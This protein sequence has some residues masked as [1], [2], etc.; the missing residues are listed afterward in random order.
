MAVIGDLIVRVGA[1]IEGFERAMG[2]VS[3]R[4]V[5][6]DRDA[7]KSIAGFDRIGDRLTDIGTT[8][9]I[10]ITAPLAAVAGASIKTAS[11]FESSMNRVSALGEITGKDLDDLRA[12]ALKLG[13]D[14][15]FSAKQA[16]DGMGELAAAGFSATQVMQAMPGVLNLAAAGQLEIAE[17]AEISA[18]VLQG[19]GLGADQAT[20]AADVLAKA[21]ASGSV[22]VQDLGN[23]FRYVG[24]VAQA[25][26]L[27]FEEVAA[28]TTLLSNAGIK[29]EAA[30]TGLRGMLA[31]LLD[32]AP[33]AAAALE[34]LGV[35]TQDA[36]E[37]LLP[38]TEIIGQLGAKGATTSD[39][40][41]IFG[42]ETA[43]A[44]QA[45]VTTGAPALQKMTGELQNAEGAAD[46]M[47]KTI[48]AGTKGAMEQF[49][50]S[51]E[52]LGISLGT[53][54]LP[55][56]N[57]IVAGATKLINEFLIPAAEWFAK[58]PSPIQNVALGLTAAAAAAG[59]LLL[60]SGQLIG[61]MTQ[62]AG[63]FEFV[64]KGMGTLTGGAGL[65]GSLG[66]M[67]SLLPVLT[68]LV[69]ALGAAIAA[70]AIYEGV[71]QIQALNKE[72]DRLYDAQSRGVKASEDQA[73][74]IGILEEVLRKHG[75]T[76]DSTGK[77][78][79]EYLGAL[80]SATKGLDD[81]KAETGAMSDAAKDLERR[82]GLTRGETKKLEDTQK[83][84]VRSAKE[85]EAQ[86]DKAATSLKR[87]N[88][89]ILI[90][91]YQQWQAEH[92]N[93]VTSVATLQRAIE[94]GVAGTIDFNAQLAELDEISRTVA[95]SLADVSK[96]EIP[97]YLQSIN[98]GVAATDQL[99]EAFKTLGVTTT[100]SLNDKAAKAQ[101]AYETIKSSGIASA[102]EVLQAERA[103]LQASIEAR[104]AAGETITQEE[105]ARLTSLNQSL[106][107]HVEEQKGLFDG[108]KNQVSTIMTDLSKG[109]SDIIFEG[110][111]FGET[112]KGIFEEMG[113]S[114]LR[115]VV[116]YLEGKLVKALTGLLD[117]PLKAVGGAIGG[118]FGI[119]SSAVSAATSAA[120]S[121]AGGAG[122][123]SGGV[124]SAVGGAASGVAGIVGAIGS[125]GS[126]AT[127]V[128]GLFQNSG[129]NENLQLIENNTRRLEI[130]FAN[131]LQQVLTYL[132]KLADIYDF[133]WGPGYTTTRE[134]QD[135]LDAF[136]SYT[137]D[138]IGGTLGEVRD[139][140]RA[141]PDRMI[142]GLADAIKPS[143]TFNV[144]VNGAQSPLATG[145]EVMRQLRAQGALLA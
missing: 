141:L 99:G 114:V 17:A 126:L 49:K 39:I 13:A 65:L 129:M 36:S 88:D 123:A 130:N 45:L 125:A 23:T 22:S 58:L 133:L 68:P 122:S 57:Q 109:I 107:K 92:R 5:A 9:S 29:G 62:V 131:Q 56:V 43:S 34:R 144:T 110:K 27:S 120:G 73:R 137:V 11:D 69:I 75:K 1:Q 7:Q 61:A 28:A 71:T 66:S 3:K 90:A 102:N 59:P 81:F 46:R 53:A 135:R 30:G 67:G 79:E 111:G 78:T 64:S 25:A 31:S 44:V 85:V 76:V 145:N 124:A 115:F 2:D 86:H 112:F 42:R 50:G 55:G 119:G 51:V 127:G 38:L 116:E 47:A 100:T 121:V 32:P 139:E 101:Q 132:P 140:I 72:L 134:M 128:I 18:N 83:A 10:G 106:S 94:S 103:A 70:W 74:E 60:V 82:L 84:V 21:A 41:T 20:R 80:R 118:L 97:A 91:K 136:Y 142:P 33:K 113:K 52:T 24:P 143:M 93:L 35:V 14:T 12:Q 37:K 8:L 15:Q 89:E 98:A 105:E 19:F 138:T 26:G 108:L 63:A 117:G 96:V 4:L 87:F 40:F 6:I 54:L 95:A 104:R 16:A 48:N 77:S